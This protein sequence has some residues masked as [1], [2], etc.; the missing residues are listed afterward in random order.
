MDIQSFKYFCQSGTGIR[1]WETL[2]VTASDDTVF[3][4]LQPLTDGSTPSRS[5]IARWFY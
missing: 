3:A 5:Q 1:P 2:I 4:D